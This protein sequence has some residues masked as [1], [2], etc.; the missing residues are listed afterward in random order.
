MKKRSA[1][2]LC[3]SLVLLGLNSA[4]AEDIE[5]IFGKVRDYAAKENYTKAIEELGWAKK[6]LEKAHFNKI[7]SML[8]KEVAGFQGGEINSQ[9]AVGITN[10][11][12]TYKKSGEKDVK[13]SLAGGS[14]G[15]G[16]MAGFAA[17][18][19]MAGMMG[20]QPG[21]DTFRIDGRTANLQVKNGRA[22]LTVFLE[23]GSFLKLEQRSAKDGSSVKSIAEGMKTEIVSLDNYLKGTVQQ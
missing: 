18:G 3:L 11:E 17:L 19:R 2:S 9:S 10:I 23:S 14:T 7:E 5:T 21:V 13:L 22:E 6:E 16:P 8:P 1:L 15:G 20:T 4:Q 12:R